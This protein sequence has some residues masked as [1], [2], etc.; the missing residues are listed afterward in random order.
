[1]LSRRR[2][3][4][5]APTRDSVQSSVRLEALPGESND[6]TSYRS[7]RIWHFVAAAIHGISALLLLI[8]YLTLDTSDRKSTLFSDTLR[9][10]DGLTVENKLVSSYDLFWVL[11][12]MPVLTALFHLLQGV[13]LV[14]DERGR[15]V[16]SWAQRYR[17]EIR[18]GLNV[19]RW[20]EYSGTAGLMTYIVGALSG[21]TNVYLLWFLS[22]ANVV[23]QGTGWL[24]EMLQRIDIKYDWLPFV[25]GTIV[26][27]T[28]WSIIIC[29][30]LRTLAAAADLDVEV[31]FYVRFIVWGLLASFAGFPAVQ[32][33]FWG[34]FKP[35]RTEEKNSW[36]W[37]EFL[38]IALS[39]VS[40]LLLD[41]TLFAGIVTE[42]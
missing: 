42:E 9:S 26:F 33:A 37:Y 11:F 31:P 40:K 13:L 41:W 21:I 19:I 1:M 35:W 27:L 20:I 3:A 36:Y 10:R 8:L 23:M 24:H 25:L 39:I 29:Y 18:A 28:Q 6:D 15:P 38:F 5:G 34:K 22:V 7:L 4:W 32:V 17:D 2:L 12:P 14:D 16:V 30:F